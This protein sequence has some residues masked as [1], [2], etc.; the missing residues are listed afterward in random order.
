M[1]MITVGI[2][3]LVLVAG[4]TVFYRVWAPL[5]GRLRGV[6]KLVAKAS[7]H[8]SGE[9]FV[10]L[11]ATPMTISLREAASMLADQLRAGYNRRPA[12]AVQP[13]TLNITALTSGAATR[14]AWLGHSSFVLRIGG[15]TV[16]FD[17]VLSRRASP[18]QFIGPKRFVDAPLVLDQLVMVDAV[19]ISHD[20][21]DHLDYGTIRSLREKVRHFFVPL[22]VGAHLERW[23][24]E[25]TAITE[26]DWWESAQLDGIELACTPSR[27]FSGRRFGDRNTTLWGSWVIKTGR[28]KVFFSG[29][30]GYGPHFAEIGQKYGPFNL[31]LME[32]GQYDSRWAN[33]H[34]LPEQTVKAAR[35][36]GS[37]LLVPIHWGS[38]VLAFHD[39][40][41]PVE[42]ALKAAADYRLPVA[43]PRIGQ[44]VTLRR[45]AN[46]TQPW[47]ET[48]SD[49]QLSPAKASA[50]H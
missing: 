28:D 29:D 45:A 30:T 31:T 27:H 2:L 40:T 14:F 7:H 22:G 5:G 24:I 1:Y 18:F 43:T 9:R 16:L 50:A 11:T 12:H 20:H 19:V 26:L 32:C 49:I 46:A 37:K 17:P 39:W 21:Y 25:R 48:V 41:E 10:N 38:F 3:L 44:V 42:R 34:M 4:A 15:K 8:H 47:W 13:D 23:G 6:R 35:D 33:I 36:L